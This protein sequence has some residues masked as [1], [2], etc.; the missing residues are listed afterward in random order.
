MIFTIKSLA[1][2]RSPWGKRNAG[3]TLFLILCTFGGV[4]DRVEAP[5]YIH[6]IAR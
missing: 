5:G 3:K 6:D 4:L 2:M 1:G